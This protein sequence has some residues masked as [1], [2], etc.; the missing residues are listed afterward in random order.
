MTTFD[1]I[2]LA[3]LALS[4]LTAFFRG[5]VRELVGIV[6]W[7]VGFV[8]AIA[9]APAFGAA[10]P[11]VPGH[12]SVRYIIAFVVIII[13]ALVAGALIAWPLT[14]VIRLAGLGFVDRFLGAIFGLL[15]GAAFVLAFVLVA[16]LTPLPQTPWWQSSLFVP[17]LVAGVMALRPYLPSALVARLDY[18]PGGA[19]PGAMPIVSTIPMRDS[20]QRS[21][22]SA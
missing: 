3:V 4:T 9:Y 11:E 13:A 2:V 20:A 16:G 21:L 12:P 7:V 17:P 15:R 10:L 14:R 18:S 19:R 6:A 22:F 1:W 8:A 5:V